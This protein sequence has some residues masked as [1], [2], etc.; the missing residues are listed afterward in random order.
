M[1]RSFT[2]RCLQGLIVE[3]SNLKMRDYQLDLTSRIGKAQ[4]GCQHPHHIAM[5]IFATSVLA[6]AD[7]CK[8]RLAAARVCSSPAGACQ[9]MTTKNACTPHKTTTSR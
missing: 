6:A 4:V 3:R 1:P 5:I 9:L 8:Q 7:H 2:R